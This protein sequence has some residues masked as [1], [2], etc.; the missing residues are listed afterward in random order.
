MALWSTEPPV[1]MSP[2]GKGGRCVRLTTSSLSYA[3]CYGI[4]KPKIT[5]TLWATPDMLGEAFTFTFVSL[6]KAD[7]VKGIIY[8]KYLNLILSVPSTCY[9]RLVARL[10]MSGAITLFPRPPFM[11][12]TRNLYLYLYLLHFSSALD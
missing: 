3:E 8:F 10:R 2:G 9:F 1:K 6:Y 4:W 5:G 12:W 11:P 7:A